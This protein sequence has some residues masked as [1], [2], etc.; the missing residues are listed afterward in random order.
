MGL[1]LQGKEGASHTK[2]THQGRQGKD[3]RPN[4]GAHPQGQQIISG[5]TQDQL[6]QNW[7]V[8]RVNA[9]HTQPG[10][11][12]DDNERRELW[13]IVRRR[14]QPMQN[15]AR[16]AKVPPPEDDEDYLTQEEAYR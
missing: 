10:W 7:A 3:G 4:L 2:G 15:T 5:F 6:F 8:E 16:E 12:D 11:L 1:V 9:V 14:Y 13:R